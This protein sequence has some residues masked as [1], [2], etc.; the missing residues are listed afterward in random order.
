[1]VGGGGD[2]WVRGGVS[3]EEFGVD[4]GRGGVDLGIVSPNFLWALDP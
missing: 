1:M 2:S 3:C 4:N